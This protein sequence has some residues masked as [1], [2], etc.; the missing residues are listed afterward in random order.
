MGIGI[1]DHI[2]D[3]AGSSV[4]D[5]IVRA[6]NRK[7]CAMPIETTI[8]DEIGWTESALAVASATAQWRVW[9]YRS[10]EIVL[11]CSQHRLHDAVVRRTPADVPVHVRSSG[12]GAVFAGPWLVGTTVVV[13]AG[14]ALLDGGLVY[15]YRWLGELHARVLNDG[16]VAVRALEPAAARAGGVVPSLPWACFGGLSPWEVVDDAGRKL[17]GLAQRR[18]RTAVAFS[19][20]TLVSRPPWRVL[21]EAL[22]APDDAAALDAFTAAC[23]EIAPLPAD[24]WAARL[25]SALR[26]ELR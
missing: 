12:G 8:A 2:R 3:A 24:E 14:H 11:G 20:G 25:D 19:A 1:D 6:A 13:P 23:D 26:A 22:G 9:R 16:G 5:S 15:S 4:H 21:C 17:T 18:K 10:P 7:D